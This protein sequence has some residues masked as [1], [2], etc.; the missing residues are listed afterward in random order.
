MKI[1]GI[2]TSCDETAAAIVED[3]QRLLSNV[4]ASSM[5]IHV[6]Y[7][8]VV[9]EIAARSHLEAIMPV[10]E[11]T[12]EDAFSAKSS[13]VKD[14]PLSTLNFKPSSGSDPWDQIDG[15]AAANGPGLGG[16]L[17]IG[18]LTART[19]AI[20]KNKPLYAIN[21]VTAHVYTNFLTHTSLP[22]F[23]LPNSQPAFPL[24]SLIVS[25]GHTQLVLFHD[26]FDYILLGQTQDD[27][28][29]EAFDKVA[30]ILGL[31]YPGGPS[32]EKKAQEGDRLA[33]KL[34]KAKMPGK[35][36]FSFSGP[37]TAVLR[38]AQQQIGQDYNFP[39]HKLAERLSEAQ[40]AN[41]AASF[42]RIALETVV[43]KTALAFQ[44][45]QPKSVVIAG[46][47]AANTELRRQIS[48][49]I[50][51]HI[52][53]ADFKLCTDNAAMVAALGYFMAAHK[54]PGADPYSLEINPSLSM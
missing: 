32:I 33:F 3:G 52:E 20:I 47:V 14:S 35:Y 48:E 17:L 41:I 42:Q 2:E 53:Y 45:F 28:V 40:K 36:D 10:I 43:D 12:V 38:L 44:E 25:G 16:S 37:K 8:G 1:L 49:R 19:L 21:H 54:Q 39:S 18:V 11:K 31:P 30:K 13:K 7:G 15:I 26:H 4:V 23:I 51:I 22:G 24:L 27:A 50:P 29:G 5:D 6:Q 34:P 9:P 46:G